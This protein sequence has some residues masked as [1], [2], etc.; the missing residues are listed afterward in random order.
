MKKRRTSSTDAGMIFP[1]IV[2]FLF[3]IGAFASLFYLLDGESSLFERE[4]A[5]RDLRVLSFALQTDL[6]ADEKFFLV[7]LPNAADGRASLQHEC[8]RFAAVHHE[9]ASVG[10]K[11]N[12]IFQW[13]SDTDSSVDF[14][15]ET[16]PA[17]SSSSMETAQRRYGIR[18]RFRQTTITTSRRS[19]P[20][21]RTRQGLLRFA[22][23]I[24][25]KNSSVTFFTGTPWRITRSPCFL[26]W[27]KG[28]H[29]RAI[30]MPNP[31]FVFNAP[32]RGTKQC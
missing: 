14:L 20:L 24:P 13:N 6:L 22:F 5:E 16:I 1:P 26:Q 3:F 9:I 21:P 4:R 29:R 19:S 11:K 10:V 27:E 32:Y 18:N 28:L 23:S 25:R 2:L 12:D 7:N 30:P 17:S 31:P 15:R 8:Q